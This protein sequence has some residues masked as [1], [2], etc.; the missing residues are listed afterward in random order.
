MSR[1]FF[2]ASFPQ[3]TFIY[4]DGQTA[5]KIIESMR[6]WCEKDNDIVRSQKWLVNAKFKIGILTHGARYR[7]KSK[8]SECAR[9]NNDTSLREER[10]FDS[11]STIHNYVCTFYRVQAHADYTLIVDGRTE[12]HGDKSEKSHQIAVFLKQRKVGGRPI[13]TFHCFDPCWTGTPSFARSFVCEVSMS[14]SEMFLWH[15][16]EQRVMIQMCFGM[17]WRFIHFCFFQVYDPY[18]CEM[19]WSIYHLKRGRK[20]VYKGLPKLNHVSI[21]YQFNR[22]NNSLGILALNPV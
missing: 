6:T 17:T 9:E 4:S 10:Y 16:E 21:H 13:Y 14:A 19:I 18:R 5:D 2:R 7:T 22:A 11:N 1:N 12:L 15:L 8:A 3:E 20:T